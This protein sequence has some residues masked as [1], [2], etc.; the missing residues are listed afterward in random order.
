MLKFPALALAALLPLF[1]QA[2]LIDFGPT[3]AVRNSDE[4]ARIRREEIIRQATAEE[5]RGRARIKAG[6]ASTRFTPIRST[7]AS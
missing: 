7:K 6:Q 1:A 2:Q 5:D 4:L 3:N